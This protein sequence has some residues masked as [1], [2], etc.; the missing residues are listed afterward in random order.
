MVWMGWGREPIWMLAL[1]SRSEGRRE[2]TV[3]EGL[4]GGAWGKEGLGAR[5]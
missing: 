3:K 5:P 4:R 1:G 2:S